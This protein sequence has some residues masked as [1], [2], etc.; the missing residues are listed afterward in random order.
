MGW[1][2]DLWQNNALLALGVVLFL[3]GLG[4]PGPATIAIVATGALVRHGGVAPLTA[5]LVGLSCAAVGDFISYSLARRGLGHWMERRQEKP[6]WQK[7][8]G[9]FHEN[10]LLTLFLARWLFT[11]LSLPATYIAGSSRYPVAKFLTAS[12]LGQTVWILVYGAIGYEVGRRWEK[13]AHGFESW[14][15]WLSGAVVVAALA[16]WWFRRRK[17]EAKPTQS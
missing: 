16:F 2:L 14:M 13:L 1:A 5:L 12:L 10:A 11:P 9:R 7:A 8:I 6:S 15:G 17:M 4:V 3:G